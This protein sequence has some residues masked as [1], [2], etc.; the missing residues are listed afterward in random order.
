MATAISVALAAALFAGCSTSQQGSTALPGSSSVSQ[1]MGHGGGGAPNK[2]IH[3]NGKV[4]PQQLLKYQ[5]AGKLPGPVT[6]AA[7]KW[8][9]SQIQGKARPQYHIRPDGGAPKAWA[10]DNNFGYLLGMSKK[11]KTLTAVNTE[12]NGCYYPVTVKVDH[13]HNVWTACEFGSSFE[14]GAAQEYSSTGSVMN[15]YNVGCPSNIGP[16]QC[17]Y[18][19]GETFDTAENNSNVF[20]NSVY[21]ENCSSSYCYYVPGG[22]IEVWNAGS[23]SSQPILITA[24]GG[25]SPSQWFMEGTGYFDADSS[26]NVYYTFEACEDTYPYACGFGLA[27]IEN[28]TS[29]SATQINLIPPGGLGFWGGVNVNGAGT[30]LSVT[31][32]DA[33]TVTQYALPWTGSP[34]ATWGPTG[35]NSFGLGD[36][37]AGGY[38]SASSKMLL[39]DAYGWLDTATASG[40]QLHGTVDCSD[41]CDGAAFTP[42]NK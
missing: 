39:G 35:Q 42:S 13:A 3:L 16:S 31:D 1:P 40:A 34:S 18:L 41:G 4:G 37:V 19:Y 23:P 28:A 27:E 6:K 32:Q 20:A 5:I 10:G 33:R 7:L 17:L 15:T 26:N 2:Y 29:P 11:F 12:D 25:L 36:P 14:A 9:L 8:Q 24:T 21:Y 22:G 30:V 38:N